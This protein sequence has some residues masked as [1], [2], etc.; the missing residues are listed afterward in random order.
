[1]SDSSRTGIQ[2]MGLKEEP[3]F[4][5]ILALLVKSKR[6]GDGPCSYDSLPNCLIMIKSGSV[7]REPEGLIGLYG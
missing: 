2:Q 4:R 7:V 5:K 6:K 1:M 3:L